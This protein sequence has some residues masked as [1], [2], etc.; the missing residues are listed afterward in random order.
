M[1][2]LQFTVQY[3]AC[4]PLGCNAKYCS[5][6][7][8]SCKIRAL[9]WPW[10]VLSL[11]DVIIVCSKVAGILKIAL[12]YFKLRNTVRTS[13]KVL[14]FNVVIWGFWLSYL[15]TFRGTRRNFSRWGQATYPVS[16]GSNKSFQL[17]L[18]FC[19]RG[20]EPKVK[21][22]LLKKCCNWPACWT[23]WCNS[24]VL[25]TGV[26]GQSPQSLGNFRNFLKKK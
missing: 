3:S 6:K 12:R 5:Q 26:W 23:N 2:G 4:W 25:L 8:N 11:A 21:I 9:L 13:Q 14:S 7:K 10:L 22:I 19:E 15:S 16:I 17:Q 24:S 18:E 1:D 20:L